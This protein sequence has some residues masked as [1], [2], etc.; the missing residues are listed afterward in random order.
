ALPALGDEGD[1]TD[2]EATRDMI[3]AA[4]ASKDPII[5]GNALDAAEELYAH[6]ETRAAINHA[7]LTRVDNEKDI[8]LA[9]SLYAFIGKHAIADGLAACKQG[10]NGPTTLAKAA[11]ECM[12]KLGE[13]PPAQPNPREAKP[14]FADVTAVIG[15]R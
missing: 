10:L 13:L 7:V 12:K 14:P 1:V 6:E 9:S 15:K 8:E 5:S 4:I 11:A 2:H 3:A